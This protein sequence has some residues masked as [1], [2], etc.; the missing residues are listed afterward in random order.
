[1]QIP[2]RCR[3]LL[4]FL[5]VL[6]FLGPRPA[7]A[8]CEVP[9][10]VYADQ[11]R[12]EGMLEDQVTIHKAMAQIRELAGAH[13]PLAVNQVVRWVNT[14]EAHAEATQRVIAQYFM[15]Q[16]IKPAD[17]NYVERLTTAH[18][19]MLAAMKCKQSVADEDAAALKAAILAF[20]QA[21]AGPAKAA[22]GAGAGKDGV[23]APLNGAPGPSHPHPHG[24]R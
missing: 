2:R 24:P 3:P 7:E 12:F 19:V 15:H 22:E 21:Y 23:Q 4:P 9:C 8:H 16:R 17:A 11:M 18:A 5:L 13:E 1:M 10:G 14:K 20:H 6:P